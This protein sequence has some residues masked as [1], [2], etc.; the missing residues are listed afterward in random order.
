MREGDSI[1]EDSEVTV[2][3]RAVTEVTEQLRSK[4][5]IGMEHRAKGD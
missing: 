3:Y 1:R 4:Q 2:S 5:N